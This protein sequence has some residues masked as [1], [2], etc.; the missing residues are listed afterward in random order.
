M[1]EKTI[2]VYEQP[3]NTKAYISLAIKL[4]R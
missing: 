2:V 3:I 1:S 4:T